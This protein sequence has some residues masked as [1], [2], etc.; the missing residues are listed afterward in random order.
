MDN[1]V[2]Y[3]IIKQNA[4]Y[5]IK[6]ISIV[7]YHLS[8]LLPIHNALHALH[9]REYFGRDKIFSNQQIQVFANFCC[10]TLLNYDFSF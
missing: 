8:S 7:I 10:V 6:K 9:E 2:T 1:D 5:I 3:M 4:L